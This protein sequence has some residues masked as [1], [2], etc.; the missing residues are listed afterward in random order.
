MWPLLRR[1]PLAR[2]HDL[3]RAGLAALHARDFAGCARLFTRAA[4]RYRRELDVEALARLRVHELIA[5]CAADPH[6]AHEEELEVERR[7]ARLERIEALTPPFALIPAHEL[8]AR[9]ISA[10]AETRSPD[11][12]RAA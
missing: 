1:S 9:W 12:S 5:R 10:S 7:L 4:A 11:L 2:A 3:H 6:A 8:M